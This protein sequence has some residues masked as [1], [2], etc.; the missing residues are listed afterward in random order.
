ML[1]NQISR[2]REKELRHICLEQAAQRCT[3]DLTSVKLRTHGQ[4]HSCWYCLTQKCMIAQVT[5]TSRETDKAAPPG[6]N[7]DDEAIFVIFFTS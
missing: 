5:K 7:I 3:R 4:V 6:G 1:L 2:S